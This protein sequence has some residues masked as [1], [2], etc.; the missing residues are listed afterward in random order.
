MANRVYEWVDERTGIKPAV[1]Y[2]LYRRIP[3]AVNWW[4]TFGSASL[5]VFTIQVVSGIFLAMGYVPSTAQVIRPDGTV[6][7]EALESIRHITTSVPFGD[8]MR[9]FHH[10]GANMMVIVVLIHALRVFFMGSY[11]YPRELTWFIGVGIL[12]MVLGFSFTGYLLPWD[13]RAYWATQ[14]GVNIGGAAPVLGGA[15]ASILK[16]GPTLGAST[17]SRFYALHVLLLPAITAGLI[18]LHLFLIVKIGI[19]GQP[20][21]KE[22]PAGEYFDT[23]ELKKKKAGRAFFPYIIFKDAVVGLIVAGLIILATI[24]WPVENANPVNP[25]N[26]YSTLEGKSGGSL[27]KT[28]GGDTVEAALKADGSPLLDAKGNQIYNKDSGYGSQI[29]V[30]PN[31]LKQIQI[32]PQPEWYFLFLFQFLKLFPGEINLGLFTLS[33][34]AIGGVI[35]PTILILALLLSPILD[36]GPK[37]SPLSR[38]ITTVIMVFVLVSMVVLTFLAISQ[39]NDAVAS[40]AIAAPPA[41]GATTAPAGAATTAA[42]AAG[43]TTTAAAGATTAAAAGGTGNAAAGSTVFRSQCQ[44]C[45]PNGGRAAGVGPNLS[46][47]ANAGDAGYIRNNVRNGKGAMPAFPPDQ[48]SDAELENLVAYIASI[49]SK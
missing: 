44:A 43:V 5:I 25:N 9:G 36:R 34:E 3:K 21:L 20:P 2:V 17:L 47:S 29:S 32:P 1:D 39:L 49:R 38:P 33:G 27:F 19:S 37:R 23:S 26:P 46:N 14:V 41:A 42:P 28:G 16:G 4:F 11:K 12:V 45:H 35:V 30:N 13:N 31:D 24:F 8:W 18:G 22:T 15:V 7:N 48:L 6:S 40:T 10:W